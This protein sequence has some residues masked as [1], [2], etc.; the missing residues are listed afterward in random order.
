MKSVL[1]FNLFVKIISRYLEKCKGK[2]GTAL[3][4][5]FVN[6]CGVLYVS[7]EI[8]LLDGV[9]DAR[10]LNMPGNSYVYKSRIALQFLSSIFTFALIR[11]TS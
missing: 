7:L 1:Y 4:F 6:K 11:K 9:G 8:L 5:F 2:L 10:N 3:G